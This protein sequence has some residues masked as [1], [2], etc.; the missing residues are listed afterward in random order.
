MTIIALKAALTSDMGRATADNISINDS[1][2]DSARGTVRDKRVLVP[3][4]GFL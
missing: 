3:Q 4:V 1:S 2:L